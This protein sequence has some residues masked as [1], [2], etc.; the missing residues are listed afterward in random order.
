MVGSAPSSLFP[1][2]TCHHPCLLYHNT[3]LQKGKGRV[4]FQ[5]QNTSCSRTMQDCLCRSGKKSKTCIQYFHIQTGC[6][7]G[8]VWLAKGI[9][10]LAQEAR[11]ERRK[12]AQGWRREI[13]HLRVIA[14]SKKRGVIVSACPKPLSLSFQCCMRGL[15]ALCVSSEALFTKEVKTKTGAGVKCQSVLDQI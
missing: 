7:P 11:G 2:P 9:S 8:E 15:K 3:L 1:F 6:S 14:S 12:I 10:S 4:F 13:S 5:K